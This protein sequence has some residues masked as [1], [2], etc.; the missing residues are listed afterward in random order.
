[1]VYRR[2]FAGA[3]SALFL[4]LCLPYGSQ[5]DELEQQ[6][7]NCNSESCPNPA[8]CYGTTYR[9]LDQSPCHFQCEDPDP[10]DPHRNVDKGRADCRQREGG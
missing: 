10:S 3:V 7:F 8:Q 9:Y 5:G 1:M 2:L 4:A 6:W